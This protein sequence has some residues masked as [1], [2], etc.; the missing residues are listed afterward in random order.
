M[1]GGG[2]AP[3]MKI[4]DLFILIGI[5][6]LV[7]GLFIHG[8]SSSKPL[9]EDTEPFSNGASLL[10][11]DV[12]KFSIDAT[13]DSVVILEVQNEKME[14][15]HTDTKS[16][17]AGGSEDMK[18]TANEGGFYTYSVEFSAGSG[19]V[20]VDVD[21][22]LLIDFIIYPIGAICLVF[23]LYKRKDDQLGETLD[24]VLED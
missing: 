13:N 19:D 10:G 15:V 14:I 8:L 5:S 11:S 22:Q 6:F 17:E 4:S 12:L 24:A 1:A 18:F 23:G 3:A 21:R 20:Y 2:S 16:I 9:P 7:G